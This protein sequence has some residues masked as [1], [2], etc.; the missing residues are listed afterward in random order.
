MQTIGFTSVQRHKA[1]R[2]FVPEH[3][4]TVHSAE[5]RKAWELQHYTELE[6]LL[7]KWQLALAILIKSQVFT[8]GMYDFFAARKFY[9]GFDQARLSE[10]LLYLENRY[11][12]YLRKDIAQSER[13]ILRS[14]QKDIYEGVVIGGVRIFP[15]VYYPYMDKLYFD[16]ANWNRVPKGVG[17]A[18]VLGHKENYIIANVHL[19][20]SQGA[21]NKSEGG[22]GCAGSDCGCKGNLEK[23]TSFGETKIKD[24][25]WLQVPTYEAYSE[26][27]KSPFIFIGYWIKT[28]VYA[29]PR[30]VT[31]CTCTIPVG[32][33]STDAAS[34]CKPGNN[35]GGWCGKGACP[36]ATCT[37]GNRG[38]PE[39]C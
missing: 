13:D 33:E 37:C 7:L 38:F 18:D 8:N 39:Y 31:D 26:M 15:E 16:H 21:D 2:G 17:I 24:V 34:W 25:D 14:V 12:A 22:C 27:V 4:Y 11:G 1:F 29:F 3:R 32:S 36:A 6:A 9:K 28:G 5:G 23:L 19:L 30:E 35:G 10:I 20:P